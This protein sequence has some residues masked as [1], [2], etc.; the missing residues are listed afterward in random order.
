MQRIG[1]TTFLFLIAVGVVVLTLAARGDR[2]SEEV[3]DSGTGRVSAAR[4]G[5]AILSFGASD[6]V[7]IELHGK[8][9][10]RATGSPLER[11]SIQLIRFE[12]DGSEDR[13]TLTRDEIAAAAVEVNE[14]TT[15]EDGRFAMADLEPGRYSLQVRWDE[16]QSEVDVVVW[17]VEWVEHPSGDGHPAPTKDGARHLER[18]GARW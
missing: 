17:A 4:E 13:T 15:D 16:I 5:H 12:I 3:E 18:M 10:D 11:T 9:T 6:G 7:S 14:G 2:R 8:L 1:R